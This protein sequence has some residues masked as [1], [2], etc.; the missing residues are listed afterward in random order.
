[1]GCALLSQENAAQE[2]VDHLQAPLHPLAPNTLL[3]SKVHLRPSTY[4]TKRYNRSS[5]LIPTLSSYPDIV[6]HTRFL[7]LHLPLSFGENYYKDCFLAILSLQRL[8]EITLE[9]NNWQDRDLEDGHRFFASGLEARERQGTGRVMSRHV[10]FGALS[11]RHDALYR[12]RQW[13]SMSIPSAAFIQ[14]RALG[15]PDAL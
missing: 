2:L 14:S 3:L 15:S 10:P 6:A 7:N 12:V 4:R 1:M 13:R 5:K 9:A 11:Q 8:E